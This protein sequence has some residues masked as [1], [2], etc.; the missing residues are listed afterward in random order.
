MPSGSARRRRGELLRIAFATPEYVT[1]EYFDGGLANY[2]YRVATALAGRGHDVHVLTLSTDDAAA[3]VHDGVTV[4][5]M[6]GGNWW[7]LDFS[8]KVYRKL[9]WLHAQ[10]PVDVVQFPNYSCCGLVSMLCGLEVPRVLRASSYQPALH[11]AAGVRGTLHSRMVE[12]LEAL[13]FRLSPHVYA[14]SRTLQDVLTTDA[15]LPGVRVIRTPFHVETRD[16]DTALYDR[17][18]KGKRFLL[19]F[20][21][22]Q[23]HKG[24]HTLAQALPRVLDHYPDACAALVGRDMASPGAPSMAAYARE[25]CGRSTGRVIILDKLPHRQLYPV[26]AGAHLLVLPSLIENLPN[27]GLEAMGLGKAVIGTSGTGFEELITDGETGFLVAPDDP[28]ALAAKIISAW[29]HPKLAD[30]GSAA[31]RKSLEFS[32]AITI[33]ALLSYY[34]DVLHQ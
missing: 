24:F 21:R 5:R 26:V 28:D 9:K 31:Q 33:E 10:R 30:I 4:H 16:W 3:F 13:Q 25:Q 15:R 34:R 23:R 2:T 19:F 14:P 20:G 11:D 32:P 7:L 22:F 6:T 12:G 29:M 8:V 18:L 17:H 27:A 1:E